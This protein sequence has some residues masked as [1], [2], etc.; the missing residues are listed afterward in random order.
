MNV[1]AN[2]CACGPRCVEVFGRGWR[3]RD[4]WRLLGW[5]WCAR[6]ERAR[7]AV[8]TFCGVRASCK[9]G[10]QVA[11]TGREQTCGGRTDHARTVPGAGSRR[12][13]GDDERSGPGTPRGCVPTTAAPSRRPA[14]MVPRAPSASAT[15]RRSAPRPARHLFAM[16]THALRI[17]TTDAAGTA[18]ASWSWNPSVCTA[19]DARLA[20]AVG[21]RSRGRQG[22]GGRRRRGRPRRARRRRGR[23]QWRLTTRPRPWHHGPPREVT[24]RTRTSCTAHQSRSSTTA[25]RAA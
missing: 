10:L 3:A 15:R 20:G 19:R 9:G 11:K 6:G 14:G 16:P 25:R 13:R 23:R 7:R 5:W 21:T 24:Q 22:G 4:A 17:G 1:R 8:S 12:R 18:L 2:G